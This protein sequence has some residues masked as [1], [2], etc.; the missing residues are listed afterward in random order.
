M[1]L[2]QTDTDTPAPATTSGPAAAPT[3]SAGPSSSTARPPLITRISF[4]QLAHLVNRTDDQ[5]NSLL[6][7]I[8]T[9]VNL[10]IAEALDPI[11]TSVHD[12]L[13]QLTERVDSLEER[14][15]GEDL[16][17]VKADLA[18]L[19]VAVQELK[20]KKSDTSLIPGEKSM[21]RYAR[22]KVT[23]DGSQSVI[24]DLPTEIIHRI[25]ELMPIQYAARTST[26][27]KKW[28]RI[29][30]NQPH[31]VFDCH[32]FQFVSENG[33]SATSIIHRILMQHTGPIRGFHLI[34]RGSH[35]GTV[36]YRSMPHLCLEA[37]Y[38]ETDSRFGQR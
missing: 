25:L 1:A 24:G 10:K 36:R 13:K 18:Q 8:P 34:S 26:L 6:G 14:V 16:T 2:E 4:T 19:K 21:N 29:W 15:G 32:F 31:L 17:T 22:R 35:T 33:S 37:W 9:F 5:L 28:R 38:R 23:T 11:R 7:E 27:S 3:T 30:S 12:R 20:S